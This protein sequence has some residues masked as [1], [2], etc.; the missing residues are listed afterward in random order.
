MHFVKAKNLLFKH[1]DMFCL[2]PYRGCTHGCIYC[3]SRSHKYKI[4]HDFEDVEI[5]QRTPELLDA[6]LA[7][8]KRKFMISMGYLNDP[9]MPCEKDLNI[10]QRLLSVI[11]KHQFGATVLTKSDLILR[12]LPIIRRIQ[13]STKFVAQISITTFDDSMSRILEPHVCA[14]SRRFNALKVLHENHIPT[15]V[16]LTPILPFINDTED[17]IASIL[18]ACAAYGVKGVFC[19]DMGLTLHKGCREYFFACLDTHFPTLKKMYLETFGDS[20][21]ILSLNNDRLMQ[22][23]HDLCQ[24]HNMLHTPDECLSWLNT[25]DKPGQQLT[26]F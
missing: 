18:E 13:R 6:E 10:T 16:R 12:D 17:N 24:K 3:E 14:S 19:P 7:S 8:R 1:E 20:E 26:L 9:Y 11:H 2:A 23:F 21:E 25:Y 22:V 15:L 4:K 5:M